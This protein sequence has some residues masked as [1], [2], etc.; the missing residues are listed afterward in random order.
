MSLFL[1]DY[2][3]EGDLTI[4]GT[5]FGGAFSGDGNLLTG[6]LAT[7]TVYDPSSTNLVGTNVQAA[8]TELDAKAAGGL[9]N[10]KFRWDDSIVAADPGSGKLRVN[11]SVYSNVTEIY[12][13]SISGDGA[14][15]TFFLEAITL[16]D[17][18][19]IQ[20]QDTST[21]F[22][23]VEVNG[24]PVDNG[25][26]WTIPC[27]HR[28]SGGTIPNNSNL[29]VA[30]RY[31][32]LSGADADTLN[33]ENGAFY[34]DYNNFNN[35]PTVYAEP[36][37]F[38]GG[39]T[40]TLASGVSAAEVRTLIDAAQSSHTHPY[41]PLAGGSMGGALI[42]ADHGTETEDQVVNVCYGTSATPP[43]AATVTEGTLYIQYTA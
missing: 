8:I 23:N 36:G 4:T 5:V 33:G 19:L 35:T 14:D 41:V 43:S 13:S 32:N 37:I 10:G 38:S 28:D 20:D 27:N 17:R 39:G 18:I 2:R 9:E 3:V 7:N 42:A 1:D 40:P 26:W 21:N 12:I 34:L 6:L 16:D 24:A 22:L 31:F 25:V 29:L 30:L 11:N 15:V